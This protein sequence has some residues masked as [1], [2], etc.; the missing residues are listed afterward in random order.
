MKGRIMI[1]YKRIPKAAA[2]D[3]YKDG[4]PVYILPS[5]PRRISK[6][7]GGPDSVGDFDSRA[8]RI[9]YHY[10]TDLSYYTKHD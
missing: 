9:Q 10:K 4:K 7:D 6:R 3:L 2:R 5:E 1:K 8:D